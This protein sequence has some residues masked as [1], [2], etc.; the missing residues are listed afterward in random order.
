MTDLLLML[1]FL[2]SEYNVKIGLKWE[3]KWPFIVKSQKGQMCSEMVNTFWTN[4][5]S[6]SCS[7]VITQL[8]LWTVFS[9]AVH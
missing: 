8:Q 9:V 4:V 7:A 5:S 1:C 6:D 3:I 2:T